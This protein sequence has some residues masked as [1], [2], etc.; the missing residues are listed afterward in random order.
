LE[1]P[2]V[3]LVTGRLGG[4]VG[5]FKFSVTNLSTMLKKGSARSTESG[6]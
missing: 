5:H 1:I 3:L 6:P 4:C 2:S